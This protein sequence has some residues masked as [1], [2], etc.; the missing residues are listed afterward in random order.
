MRGYSGWAK[1]SKFRRALSQLRPA[2]GDLVEVRDSVISS[3]TA[4][5]EAF[6]L[7]Q[8]IAFHFW[9]YG[10][11]KGMICRMTGYSGVDMNKSIRL[12]ASRGASTSVAFSVVKTRYV[13]YLGDVSCRLGKSGLSSFE[14]FWMDL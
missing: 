3:A 2:V 6:P 11:L 8:D 4:S 9:D 10:G 13:P 7:I 5:L 12:I 14:I 1:L